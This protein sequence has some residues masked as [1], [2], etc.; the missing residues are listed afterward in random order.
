MLGSS[1]AGVGITIFTHLKFESRSSS[2]LHLST[3][4]N[5]LGF[6]TWLY[7]SQ[8]IITF[9]VGFAFFVADFLAGERFFLA[10]LDFVLTQRKSRFRLFPGLHLLTHLRVFG[11]SSLFT[12]SQLSAFLG[13]FLGGIYYADIKI[14]NFASRQGKIKSVVP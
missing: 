6:N 2:A 1:T 10:V 7:C 12:F 11:C 9:T 8:F 3:H 14:I 5:V 4:F 13:A